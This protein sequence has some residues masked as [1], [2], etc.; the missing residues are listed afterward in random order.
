MWALKT[1]FNLF[2]ICLSERNYVN[3]LETKEKDLHG[4]RL[5]ERALCTVSLVLFSL[6]QHEENIPT[7]PFLPQAHAHL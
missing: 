5:L 4:S 6:V 3:A 1:V 7:G 2:H